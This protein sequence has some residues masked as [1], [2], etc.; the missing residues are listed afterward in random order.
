MWYR[1]VWGVVLCGMVWG[2]V[3]YEVVTW[4]VLCVRCG[5][6][7]RCTDHVTTKHNNFFYSLLIYSSTLSF[8]VITI[9]SELDLLSL[10]LVLPLRRNVTHVPEASCFRQRNLCE[11]AYAHTRTY[12]QRLSTWNLDCNQENKPS[13]MTMNVHYVHVSKY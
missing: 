3:W 5:L 13:S 9:S 6:E 4:C 1:V 11:R 12:R 8:S 10:P 2:V 7:S